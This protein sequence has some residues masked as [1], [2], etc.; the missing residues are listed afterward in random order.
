M[1]RFQRECSEDWLKY[2]R[3]TAFHIVNAGPSSTMIRVRLNWAV[4]SLLTG[5]GLK[6]DI[7]LNTFGHINKGVPPDQKAAELRAANLLSDGG[8]SFEK[9]LKSSGYFKRLE[10]VSAK[11]IPNLS[12]SSG[13]VGKPLLIHTELKPL[14]GDTFSRY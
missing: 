10:S 12:Y 2:R 7:H 14:P 5:A 4:A 13:V 11:I 8:T 9:Y 6:R 3:R 1:Q